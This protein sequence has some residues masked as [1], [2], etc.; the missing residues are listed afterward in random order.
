MPDMYRE[1]DFEEEEEIV[2]AEPEEENPLVRKPMSDD[3]MFKELLRSKFD[4]SSDGYKSRQEETRLKAQEREAKAGKLEGD[5]RLSD[6]MAGIRRSGAIAGGLDPNIHSGSRGGEMRKEAASLRGA[7]EKDSYRTKKEED[8]ALYGY[9]RERKEDNW[10]QKQ[11]DATLGRQASTAEKMKAREAKADKRYEEKIAREDAKRQE[12]MEYKRTQAEEKKKPKANEFE[13][14]GFAKRLEQSENIFNTLEE[15]GFDRSSSSAGIKSMI[16]G[17]LSGTL[18]LD[19][20][21][22][23]RQ[24]Q[25]ERN[26]INAT[27][28]RESGAAISEGE[29]DNAEQQYFP[30]VGDTPNVLAQKKANRQQVLQSIKTEGQ[31]AYDKIPSVEMAAPSPVKEQAMGEVNAAESEFPKTVTNAQ[32]GQTATVSSLEEL[33]EARQEGFN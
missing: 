27:L 28:R 29:F 22:P 12:D 32:T 25:A 19:V 2:A 3:E 20:D 1:G 9:L 6:I 14:A 18:G 15:E 8:D 31:R 5:A 26:F 4:P 13:A 24:E 7:N 30:R 11:L 10:K 17:F 23:R 16:P 33:E 21:Q